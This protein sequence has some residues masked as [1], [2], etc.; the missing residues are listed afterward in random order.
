M[1]RPHRFDNEVDPGPVQIQARKV[2]FDVTDIGL[3]WTPGHPVAS[4]VVSLAGEG[5]HLTLDL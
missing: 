5:S 2:H 1:L 4:N 3:H